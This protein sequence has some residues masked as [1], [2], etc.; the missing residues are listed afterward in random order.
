MC[1]GCG[2]VRTDELLEQRGRTGLGVGELET[3]QVSVTRRGTAHVTDTR[4]QRAEVVDGSNPNG[5][6]AF[7]R[8]RPL[9]KHERTT[10][11]EI[12]NL[13]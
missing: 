11:A 9:G 4:L 6:K 3:D 2:G 8:Q 12:F 7:D 1:W 10:L 5:V 13:Y